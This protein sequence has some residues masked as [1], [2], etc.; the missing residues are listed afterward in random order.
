M[1][2]S[3]SNLGADNRRK[4]SALSVTP[5]GRALP[6]I[7]S[8]LRTTRRVCAAPQAIGQG[9]L[10]EICRGDRMG[11]HRPLSLPVPTKGRAAMR[12]PRV[13]RWGSPAARCDRSRVERRVQRR[14]E[15]RVDEAGQGRVEGR[16]ERRVERR[17]D[18]GHECRGEQ[19]GASGQ[20]RNT[21]HRAS[22]ASAK[23]P[24]P[25]N[26]L[27]KSA[28]KSAP[29]AAFHATLHAT[30]HAALASA[31]DTAS[32]AALARAIAPAAD[33]TVYAA[34]HAARTGSG[35]SPLKRDIL[36]H[37]IDVASTPRFSRQ[38]SQ[39]NVHVCPPRSVK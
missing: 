6:V 39:P 17:V 4:M 8:T 3:P 23:G 26:R 13:G 12:K 38:S 7:L 25:A 24:V 2:T 21:T 32:Y 27:L 1:L 9:H 29:H 33:T 16:V 18:P 36:G 37:G 11:R 20:G 31:I 14:V 5:R 22:A 28:L 35:E 30:L 19:F 15:R 10:L 34:L